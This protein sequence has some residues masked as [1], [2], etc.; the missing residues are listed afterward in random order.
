MMEYARACGYVAGRAAAALLHPPPAPTSPSFSFLRPPP[1]PGFLFSPPPSNPIDGLDIKD[2]EM[3]LV[4]I[5]CGYAAGRAAAA[6]LHPPPAPPSPSFSVLRS[7]PSP[8]SNPIDGMKT[9]DGDR[10]EPVVDMRATMFRLADRMDPEIFDFYIN[11]ESNPAVEARPDGDD[12]ELR[13]A[14]RHR[15]FRSKHFSLFPPGR[16]TPPGWTSKK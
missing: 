13:K 12:D 1:S 3:R 6:L 11:S 9:R 10:P 15:A 4:N 16:G 5:A 8:P 14:L 7:P 2:A